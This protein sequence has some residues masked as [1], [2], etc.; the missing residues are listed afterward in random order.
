M[1]RVQSFKMPKRFYFWWLFFK[2]KVSFEFSKEN[3]QNNQ[4]YHKR[5]IMNIFLMNID[6][7]N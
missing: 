4:F 5:S 6:Q 7:K 1:K 3:S 2:K